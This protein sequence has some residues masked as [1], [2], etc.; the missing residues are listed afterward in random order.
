MASVF[1]AKWAKKDVCAHSFSFFFAAL[2][3]KAFLLPARGLIPNPKKSGLLSKIFNVSFSPLCA[4]FLFRGN[5]E[6]AVFFFVCA[7]FVC[8]RRINV[9]LSM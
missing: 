8:L 5:L 4:V 9:L 7:A 2:F 6:I 3:M 1:I